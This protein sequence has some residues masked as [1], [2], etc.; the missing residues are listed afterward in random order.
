M[1]YNLKKQD[2]L[3]I[4]TSIGITAIVI[5]VI[6]AGSLS[7][8]DT[9]LKQMKNTEIIGIGGMTD[10]KE[11]IKISFDK[12][13]LDLDSS[14]G[15]LRANVIYQGFQPQMGRVLLE[16]YSST[17]DK[18]KESILI[19]KQRGN[20]VYEA[21]FIQHF[22][23]TD[24]EENQSMLGQHIM[25]VSTDFGTLA[26]QVPFNVIMSSKEQ[27]KQVIMVQSNVS[28]GIRGILPEKTSDVGFD[29]QV[30]E[31]DLEKTIIKKYLTKILKE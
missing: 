24:F 21:D 30:M 18:I 23:K 3:G 6:F 9:S 28:A 22:D 19:L 16:V 26:K 12:Q 29:L 2:Q 25:R 27:P 10:I 4:F 14:D 1:S 20:D 11:S 13:S 15:L 8:E 17:G 31:A 5:G 7:S